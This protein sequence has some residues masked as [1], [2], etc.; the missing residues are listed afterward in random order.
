M[1]RLL[2]YDGSPSAR[3]A[4]KHAADLHRTGDE[5][6]VIH[7]AARTGERDDDL[8]DARHALAD[9]GIDAVSIEA[10]GSPAHAICV[11][12]ERDRY[13][14]IVVG[15]RNPRDTGLVLLGSVSSRVVAGATCHVVV[16]A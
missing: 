16:V 7:V 5:M 13:D 8:A 15:R 9:R 6:G 10:V 1:R 14:T 4:L 3:R 12:A 2:A 11:A